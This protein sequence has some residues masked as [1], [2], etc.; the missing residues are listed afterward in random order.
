MLLSH[1]VP[2]LLCVPV[3]PRCIFAFLL[4]PCSPAAVVRV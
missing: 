3:I 4:V 1:P 2:L